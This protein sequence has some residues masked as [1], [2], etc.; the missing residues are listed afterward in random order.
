MPPTRD[1]L[2]A[3]PVRELK[4]MLSNEGYDPHQVYGIDKDELVDKLVVL[5]QNPLK[6]DEYPLPLYSNC[7]PQFILRGL[8]L[9]GIH[10]FVVSYF[11]PLVYNL[12]S[13]SFLAAVL[14]VRNLRIRRWK[15]AKA[16]KR[17]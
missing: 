3:M 8:F 13:L 12:V 11:L 15:A 1:E 16:R 17:V 10:L 5:L 14:T 9:G 2:R 4:E 6:D 7:M